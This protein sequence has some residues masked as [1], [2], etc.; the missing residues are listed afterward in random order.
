MPAGS[1]AIRLD[2]I[3]AADQSYIRPDENM[4]G[5]AHR[6]ERNAIQFQVNRITIGINFDR[7]VIKIPRREAA[8]GDVNH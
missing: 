3:F 7:T 6:S 1:D 2:N 8:I 5:I 4:I